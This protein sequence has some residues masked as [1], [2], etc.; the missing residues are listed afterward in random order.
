MAISKIR[1]VDFSL[2]KKTL[3]VTVKDEVGGFVDS[4]LF[5]V[6]RRGILHVVIEEVKMPIEDNQPNPN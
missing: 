6:V 4:K 3:L 1:N 2:G 5:E